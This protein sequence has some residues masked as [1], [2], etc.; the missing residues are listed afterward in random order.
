[1]E[2]ELLAFLD[3]QLGS[4]VAAPLQEHLDSCSECFEL[5]AARGAAR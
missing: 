5:L 2:N 3:G 4:E 1:M